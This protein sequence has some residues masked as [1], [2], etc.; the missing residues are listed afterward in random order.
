MEECWRGVDE[1]V[2]TFVG[3]PVQLDNHPLRIQ[4]VS[5]QGV[6]ITTRLKMFRRSTATENK[7]KWNGYGATS[8]SH[9]NGI[10][11]DDIADPIPVGG[12]RTEPEQ[13]EGGVATIG[14]RQYARAE[15]SPTWI[16]KNGRQSHMARALW[17]RIIGRGRRRRAIV[18]LALEE[19]I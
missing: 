13:T 3:K 1:R 17:S 11:L 5:F 19:A 2:G 16:C 9:G 18:D 4:E 8:V 14:C 10:V 12:N 7:V 15:Q 6:Q